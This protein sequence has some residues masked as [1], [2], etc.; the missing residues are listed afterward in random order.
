MV[1]I[2]A[3]HR[4]PVKSAR[5]L[6]SKRLSRMCYESFEVLSSTLL[7]LN[8][9]YTKKVKAKLYHAPIGHYNHP[10]VNWVL[11]DSLH[12]I[13]TLRN[14]QELNEQYV[15]RYKK[16]EA[17]CKPFL[18]LNDV[19]EEAIKH[20]P[21]TRYDHDDITRIQFGEFFNYNQFRSHYVKKYDG[22]TKLDPEVSVQT[23][24]RLYLLHK[25]LYLDSRDVSWHGIP[26]PI[27]AY[28]PIYRSF[29]K[30]NFGNPTNKPALLSPKSSEP[31]K[32]LAL[33]SQRNKNL[34]SLRDVGEKVAKKR[35][36]LVSSK[37]RDLE[38][39]AVFDKE[40]EYRYYLSRQWSTAIP[41]VV[42]ML[43]PSTADAFKDDPT[44]RTIE[45]LAK[46][47]NK[48]GYIIVNTAALRATEPS[49]MLKH[50]DPYGEYNERVIHKA[51]SQVVN[52]WRTKP[53]V[54][55]AYGN[56]AEKLPDSKETLIRV[57]NICHKYGKLKCLKM[58][59]KGHPQHPLYISRDVLPERYLPW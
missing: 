37:D 23:R 50:D 14:A 5:A 24:Y 26:P 30:K 38:S 8:L 9:T 17:G 1:N 6:D 58:T 39:T 11:E 32:A 41:L 53:D 13:W 42:L 35:L 22:D 4:C 18:L 57:T 34:L 29:L 2:F 59:K 52:R 51:L 49:D 25:W 12:F 56:N 33:M 55:L 19:M 10:V 45:T 27:W 28:N 3:P 47:W 43:N 48:G 54:L 36:K 20:L 21:P 15:L 44:T 16:E 40:E 46:N 31:I 7:K